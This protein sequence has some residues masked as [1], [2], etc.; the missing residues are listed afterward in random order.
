MESVLA[1]LGALLVR[2]L[3]TFLLVLLLHFYLKAM[4]YKPLDRVLGERDAATSG[5]KKL[6]EEALAGADRKAAGYE[7]ALRAARSEIYREQEA[8]RRRFRNDQAAAV[9]AGRRAA[10]NRVAEARAAISR[11]KEAQQAA[12]AAHSDGL[13]ERIAAAILLGRS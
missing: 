13:A 4:F 1:S 10:E 5:L 9:A 11:E 8:M 7:E 3:P 6:A 12:L 2:A